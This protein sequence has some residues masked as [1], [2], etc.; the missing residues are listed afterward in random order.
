MATQQQGKLDNLTYDLIAIIHEKSHGLEAYDKYL[1]DA[2]GNQQVADVLQQ[3][4]QQD[5]Q[6]V[7]Q[8]AGVLRQ[9]LGGS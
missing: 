2:Q 9:V 5:E 7:Q 6:A 4:R 1:Q 8:L 3:I